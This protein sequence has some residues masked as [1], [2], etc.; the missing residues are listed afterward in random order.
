[1]S[2]KDVQII[3]GKSERTARRQ[4]KAIRKKLGK[5]DHHEI[6][7]REFCQYKGLSEEE[8]L[9]KLGRRR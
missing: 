8:V 7:V 5:E 1:M 3:T 2:I 6:T 4:R 9:E